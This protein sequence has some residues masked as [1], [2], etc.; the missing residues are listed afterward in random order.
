MRQEEIIIGNQ[1]LFVNNGQ[2]EHKA[3]LHNTVC[4]VTSR[5]KGKSNNKAFH[6][7][8]S[9]HQNILRKAAIKPIT[10]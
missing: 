1:Y 7:N 6:R 5:V 2:R 9:M 4:T 8:R 3:A 10:I